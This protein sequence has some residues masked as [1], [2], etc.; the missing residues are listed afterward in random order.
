MAHIRVQ[1]YSPTLQT[2]IGVTVI[3]P[4]P[5]S[6]E[7][8]GGEDL[9]WFRPGRKYQ[10][11]YLLHGAYGD[12]TDWSRLTGIERYAQRA[13]IAVV[14][15][16]AGNSYYQDMAQGEAY[17]T[18]IGQELPG[19]MHTLFP[20]S[21]RREDTFIAG[22]SMGGYG[23]FRLALEHPDRFCAAA[24]L[25]GALDVAAALTLPRQVPL[26]FDRAF[27]D[28]R[29]IAGSPAD[30]FT[31]VDQRLK[32]GALLPRWFI[33]CGTEDFLYAGNQKAQT[34]W[35]RRKLD[36]T[37]EEHPGVHDWEY[38]DTHIRRVIAWLPLRRDLVD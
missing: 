17:L 23:A 22:L 26:P 10:T 14:M 30:L 38:W 5:D 15:P 2:N 1:M 4:S 8:T 32:E 20:L 6:G 11:L 9:S 18:A 29:H 33:S 19:Q 37:Y 28:P 36:L 25:S 35:R 27:A 21:M 7:H 34:E 13:R 24:S 12:S 16:S 3:L 31:L